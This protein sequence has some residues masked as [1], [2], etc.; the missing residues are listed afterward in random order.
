MSKK[1]P[2][3]LSESAMGDLLQIKFYSGSHW[4][5]TRAKNYLK[6][7]HDQCLKI[8][9]FPEMGID[10]LDIGRGI[11]YIAVESHIVFYKV[12]DN[13][14]NIARILHQNMDFAN[15]E[16]FRGIIN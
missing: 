12:H 1:A 9:S 6:D 8:C 4:G 10:A 5:K 13:K 7:I 14:V 16:L 11:R 15:D 3:I 2:Y